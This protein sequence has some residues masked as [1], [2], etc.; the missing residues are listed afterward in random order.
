M[1]KIIKNKILYYVHM[2]SVNQCVIVQGVLVAV[3]TT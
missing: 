1:F 2:G 3:P